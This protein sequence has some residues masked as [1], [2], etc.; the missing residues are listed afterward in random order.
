MQ[1]ILVKLHARF[2][3]RAEFAET[4]GCLAELNRLRVRSWFATWSQEKS[5]VYSS[6]CRVR[7]LRRWVQ[8]VA[9]LV[10]LVVHVPFPAR[11]SERLDTKPAVTYLQ[12][13]DVYTAAPIEGGKAGGLARVATLAQ[14]LRDQGHHVVLVLAGDFLSPSVA[15]NIFLGGQMVA[16]LNATGISLATLGNHEFDMGVPV[17]LDRMKEAQWQWVVSN[18]LDEE[19]GAPIGRAAPC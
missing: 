12:L 4:N 3:Y 17:L 16:A 7:P 5:A 11:A 19:T 6:I 13:N 9:C 8:T 14:R 15:S 10:L 1:E 2:L 18:V